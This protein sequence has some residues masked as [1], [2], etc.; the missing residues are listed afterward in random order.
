MRC[1]RASPWRFAW[2]PPSGTSTTP[3]RFTRPVPKKWSPCAEARTRSPKRDALPCGVLCVLRESLQ[4]GLGVGP[5]SAP[6]Q[7][8]LRCLLD[9]HAPS[10][11]GARRMQGFRPQ[12]E[13]GMTAAVRHVVTNRL[14]ADE[15]DRHV[16]HF[17]LQAR[18]GGVDDEVIGRTLDVG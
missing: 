13:R 12:C 10:L 1:C 2:A 8:R 16:R 7:E 6:E 18:R 11:G 17:T 9:Q 4:H 5:D 3:W 14:F 15:A